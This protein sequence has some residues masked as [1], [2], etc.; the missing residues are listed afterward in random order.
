MAVL[1]LFLRKMTKSGGNDKSLNPAATVFRS[2]P[3]GLDQR[4]PA[5]KKVSRGTQTAADGGERRCVGAV[6]HG[7]QT[8]EIR[9]TD[10][11]PLGSAKPTRIWTTPVVFS[12]WE[13]GPPIQKRALSETAYSVKGATL[14]PW[15][16]TTK[17]ETSSQSG[18]D[19]IN[20]S[21]GTALD[22]LC[23]TAPVEL[24]EARL[25]TIAVGKPTLIRVTRKKPSTAKVT[26]LSGCN[27]ALTPPTTYIATRG[28]PCTGYRPDQS[29]YTERRIEKGRWLASASSCPENTKPGH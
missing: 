28:F 11:R 17:D 16:N 15:Q 8:E 4:G 12:S 5:R 25:V 9:A 19:L 26:D 6:F 22:E 23:P 13:T 2:L 1:T 14:A 27:E 24:G 3:I 10:S 20:L 7:R 21:M 18:D 29:N